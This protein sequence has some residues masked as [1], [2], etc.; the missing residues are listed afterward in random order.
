MDR[1]AVSTVLALDLSTHSGWAFG[2]PEDKPKHGVWEL[3]R[4]GNHGRYFSCLAEMLEG[5]IDV[6]K[7][8]LVVFEAPL[9]HA[10]EKFRTS[11]AASVRVLIGLCAVT[12]MICFEKSVQCEEASV[13]DARQL[14]MGAQP[15]DGKAGVIQFCNVLGWKP[16]DD[17]AADALILWQYRHLLDVANQRTKKLRRG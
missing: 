8:D 14:V 3:G 12:E 2:G 10:S 11:S 6:M 1:D 5:T 9:P 13:R 15:K 16:A 4:D 7:P 17:N